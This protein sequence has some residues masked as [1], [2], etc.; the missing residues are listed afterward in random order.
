MEVF[1]IVV[2]AAAVVNG[3]AG[4]ML[5]NHK[6]AGGEGFVFGFLFGPIG[7]VMAYAAKGNRGKCSAC[8]MLIDPEARKCPFCQ[9]K[10]REDLTAES[11]E[12]PRANAKKQLEEI[13][14]EAALRVFRMHKKQDRIYAATIMQGTVDAD[15][16][17]GIDAV[18]EE[19]E[20]YGLV[21]RMTEQVM[22]FPGGPMR[23]RRELTSRGQKISA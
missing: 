16:V 10:L 12:S 2:F 8:R 21:K 18:Y 4:M 6:G 14:S 20:K 17:A 11:S 5:G 15:T 3:F 13:L 22:A 1:W 7:L 23:S 9:S 19:L